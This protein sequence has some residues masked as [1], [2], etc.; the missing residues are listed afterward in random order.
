MGDI[1]QHVIRLEVQMSLTISQCLL[2]YNLHYTQHINYYIAGKSSLH[3]DIVLW[4]APKDE[5]K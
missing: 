2:C 3:A 4:V 5:D 1:S